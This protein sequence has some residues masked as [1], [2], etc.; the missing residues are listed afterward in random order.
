[1]LNYQALHAAITDDAHTIEVVKSSGET[2]ALRIPP[3]RRRYRAD[4]SVKAVRAEE[5]VELVRVL[6]KD[7]AVLTTLRDE[8]AAAAAEPEEGGQLMLD[9][10]ARAVEVV[11][12]IYQRAYTAAR[13]SFA[14]SL[15]GSSKA[16]EV[17]AMT[18]S[19]AHE[20]MAIAQERQREAQ[21]AQIEAVKTAAASTGD[22]NILEF[23]K[24][25]PAM[26]PMFL[27]VKQL[28]AGSPAPKPAPASSPSAG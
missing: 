17:M 27:Q 22:P 3:R 20:V 28:M 8:E 21:D 18:L 12:G 13:E 7:G 25:L 1:M 16:V 14:A 24:E 15:A 9:P 26:M 4:Q 10:Y 2:L 6:S 11:D 23:I 5:G 19:R